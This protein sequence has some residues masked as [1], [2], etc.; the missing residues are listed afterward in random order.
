MTAPVIQSLWIGEALSNLERLCIQSFLSHGHE[1]H[2]YVYAGIDGVPDGALMK[3]AGDILPARAVYRHRRGSFALFADWFR[4]ELLH[5]RGNWWADMDV[6]CLR[7]FDFTDAVV[8]GI[9]GGYCMNHTMKFPAHHDFC[10]HMVERCARPNMIFAEDS[11]RVCARKIKRRLK[12]LGKEHIAWGESGGPAGFTAAAKRFG[13]IRAA[14]PAEVFAPEYAAHGN[15]G[16]WHETLLRPTDCDPQALFPDSYSLHI[17]NENLRRAGF[18][19]NA[20]YPPGSTLGRLQSR[21]GV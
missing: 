6:V 19:K 21:H 10:A 13:L 20:A 16:A 5:Q 4:W 1:F 14:K 17:G 15:A 11:P 12:G 8:F 18:D 3:D 2:L 7:K 9:G